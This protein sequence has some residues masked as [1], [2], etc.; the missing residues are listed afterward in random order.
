MSAMLLFSFFLL[1]NIYWW[2][3]ASKRLS[4]WGL[5]DD[6]YTLKNVWRYWYT[7]TIFSMYFAHLQVSQ[8]FDLLIAKEILLSRIRAYIQP[9]AKVRWF[10]HVSWRGRNIVIQGSGLPAISDARHIFLFLFDIYLYFISGDWEIS[11]FTICATSLLPLPGS[12]FIWCWAVAQQ[13]TYISRYQ[14]TL[15]ASDYGGFSQKA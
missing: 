11:F 6:F 2:H 8:R 4:R 14:A 13:P 15:A 9:I 1:I 5:R 7:P 12:L 10:S 3:S